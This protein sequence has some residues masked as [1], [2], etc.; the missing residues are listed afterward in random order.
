KEKGTLPVWQAC[1]YIRQAAL[2][3][4]H[5]HEA[6]LV[7]RDIKPSNLLVAPATGRGADP[8]PGTVKVLDMGLARLDEASYADERNMTRLGQVIGTPNYLAPEQAVDAHHVDGRAD[9]Y[10]LGCTLYFL[11]TGAP[12]FDCGSLP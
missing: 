6:G 2:G 10:S 1:E 5:A 3:L 4:Q 9:V 11:L 12:P 7:H 8:G